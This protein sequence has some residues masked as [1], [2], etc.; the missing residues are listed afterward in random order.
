M[1][2]IFRDGLAVDVARIEALTV[3]KE[4]EDGEFVYY[5]EAYLTD[6]AQYDLEYFETQ[7]DAEKYVEKL[8]GEIN[9]L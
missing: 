9:N 7:D 8:V 3:S 2:K 1:L 6:G 5:V 4:R